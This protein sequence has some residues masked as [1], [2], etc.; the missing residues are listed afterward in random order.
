MTHNLVKDFQS[1]LWRLYNSSVFRPV[2]DK[3]YNP[4]ADV[5][6]RSTNKA[7]SMNMIQFLRK[8]ID[9]MSSDGQVRLDIDSL[10]FLFTSRDITFYHGALNPAH[11]K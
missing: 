1:A 4:E 2:E 7:R 3:K 6:K 10:A 9:G 11:D 8:H 5:H